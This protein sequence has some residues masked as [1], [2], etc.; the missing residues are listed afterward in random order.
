[1]QNQEVIKIIDN[2]KGR[3]NYEEKKAAKLGFSSLYAYI[4]DKILKQ[5]KLAEVKEQELILDKTDNQSDIKKEDNNKTNC[6]C[7]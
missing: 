1:M 5:R 4:E 3:R 7:C 2:L 6:N